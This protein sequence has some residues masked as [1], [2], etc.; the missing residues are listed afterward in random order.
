MTDR[1]GRNVFV[2]VWAF[3]VVMLMFGTTPAKAQDPVTIKVGV[4]EYGVVYY[5]EDGKQHGI[6]PILINLLNDL[7][8]DYRFQLAETSSRRRYRALSSGEIDLVLLESSQWEW[9]ELDVSFSD[10][11]VTERDVY[12]TSS[13]R[14]D[15]QSLFA[16]VT[17]HRILC[18]L[19]FHY[20]FAEFN[21]NPQY[22]RDNFDVLLRYNEKD[23][24]NGVLTD[25][26]P[27]GIV[28]AGFLGRQFVADSRMRDRVVIADEPDGVYDLVSVLSNK[29][30]ISLERLNQLIAQLRENGEVDRL[31][32]QLHIGLSD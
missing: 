24:L 1:S 22:L 15:A 10:R 2:K 23:V 4:Y 29:S 7:Q 26:A 27:I 16:D 12:L 32:Q 14:L 19:G 3:C 5:F 21:A 28:S 18:V 9:Q 11:I 25:E 6:A 31:W 8:D 17:A 20:G 13:S 30:A